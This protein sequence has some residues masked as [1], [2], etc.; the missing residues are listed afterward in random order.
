[1]L[2]GVGVVWRRCCKYTWTLTFENFW[3]STG[4]GLGPDSRFLRLEANCVHTHLDINEVVEKYK[5]FA[6][7]KVVYLY[8][9]S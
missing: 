8:I 9:V 4:L 2:C 7:S 5:R 1:V 6:I 3:Q